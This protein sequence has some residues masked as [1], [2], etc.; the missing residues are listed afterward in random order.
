[1]LTPTDFPLR[2]TALALK[3]G[4]RSLGIGALLNLTCVLPCPY[5]QSGLLM[6]VVALCGI[7]IFAWH[8]RLIDGYSSTAP[9][10]F[11][12]P[13]HGCF[14]ISPRT[15]LTLLF[16]SPIQCQH[17]IYLL[18]CCGWFLVFVTMWPVALELLQCCKLCI[19]AV[20]LSKF[21]SKSLII[22]YST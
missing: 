6:K 9:W 4:G 18:I 7:S 1:M 3:R 17:F 19:S 13:M 14:V 20:L 5:F 2:A 21:P 11:P 10:G 22:L 15:D 16:F 12:W 8:S